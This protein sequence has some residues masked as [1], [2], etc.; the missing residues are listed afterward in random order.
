MEDLVQLFREVFVGGLTES[1]RDVFL[2]LVH[3][4]LKVVLA[5]G[6][7]LVWVA[8]GFIFLLAGILHALRD[9]PLSDAAAH[10][11]VGGLALAAGGILLLWIR[12]T[13]SP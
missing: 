10:A 8:T 7:A 11:V 1:L 9:I 12:S 3:D 5:Y 2:G 4:A 6:L 13:R